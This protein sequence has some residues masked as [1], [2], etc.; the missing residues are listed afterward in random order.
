MKPFLILLILSAITA[1]EAVAPPESKLNAEASAIVAGYEADVAK[2]QSD[3]DQAIQAR[4]EKAKVGLAKAQENAT[5]KG[6]LDSALAIK[7]AIGKLPKG[8]EKKG[9]TAPPGHANNSLTGKYDYVFTNGHKGKL[10]ITGDNAQDIG[11]GVR[12]K[13]THSKHEYTITWANGT[14][15]TLSMGDKGDCVAHS[16]S[17]E[18]GDACLVPVK[19]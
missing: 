15:W 11:S 6:D 17:T 14:Q 13:V 18:D 16:L 1:E 5:K 10:T 3:Q 12:G 2:I 19:E 8:L 7:D 9:L 4:A